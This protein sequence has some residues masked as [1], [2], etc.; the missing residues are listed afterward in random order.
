MTDKRQSLPKRLLN[1]RHGLA[2]RF[3]ALLLVMALIVAATGMFGIAKITFVGS[4]VQQMIRTRAAQEKIAILMKVAVQESRVHLL[5]ALAASSPATD[6]KFAMDDYEMQ[7]DRL[8]NYVNLLLTGNDKVG[9]EP[10]PPGSTLERKIKAVRSAWADF[11]SAATALMA[12]KGEHLAGAKQDPGPRLTALLN[13]PIAAATGKVERA[14]DDL[15]VTMGSLMTETREQVTEVQRQARIALL[16]VIIS[17]IVLALLLGWVATDRLVIRPLLVLKG[18]AEKI[19]TGD[20]SHPLPIRGRGEISQLGG[21]I[22]A[23]AANLSSLYTELEQRVH[24]RTA[25]LETANQL[26]EQARN[27]A[28]SA[29]IAK[30]SF[31]AHMSHEIRT[32]M[33][34]IIGMTRLALQT[35]LTARQR[36]YLNKGL[37]A[38]DSLL[39]IINDILDFSKIEAG[40]L[41]LESEEFLLENLFD[42]LAAVMSEQSQNKRLEFLLQTSADVPPSLVGDALRLGQV[43]INLCSNA[44]KFTQAG[45]VVLSTRLVSRDGEQLVLRFSVRDTGIGMSPEEIGRLFVP[46]TQADASITRKYGGTGLGLAICKKLVEMMGGAIEIKSAPGWGSEFSFTARFGAGHLEPQRSSTR[47]CELL[48][49]R[50]LIIDD[51]KSSRDI[52][53]EQ[54][55]SLDFRVAATASAREGIV[56]LE[57]AA[58]EPYELVIMDWIMPELDGIAAAALI[59]DQKTLGHKPKIILTTAYDC[60]EARQRATAAGLDGYFSKP[61]NL[62][63]LFDTIMTIFGREATLGPDAAGTRISAPRNGQVLHGARILLAEDNE[64]NQQV[65]VEY[66]SSAGFVTTVAANGRQALDRLRSEP[67]AAV[68]MDIQMPVMDGYETT[69]EIRAIPELAALPVIAMTAHA[70]TGTREKCLKAGMNDYLTKPIHLDELLSVLARWVRPPA[71]DIV[72]RPEPCPPPPVAD[73]QVFLPDLLPGISIPTGLRMC[74]GKR[75][76]FREMLLLFRETSSGAAAE[77]RTH[78]A[79]GDHEA[80]AK[81]AHSLKTT[82]GIIGAGA[83]VDI[84]RAIGEALCSAPDGNQLDLVGVFEQELGRIISSIDNGLTTAASSAPRPDTSPVEP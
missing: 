2:A 4:S 9:I 79:S 66:L 72:S 56:E 69:R 20:L 28:E 70:M 61:V 25:D 15:L 1:L 6:F 58:G 41:E 49:K 27:A 75:Q 5:E 35:D 76:L 10:A 19:S 16:S 14:I 29:N 50:V 60:E 55:A 24:E 36:E 17:A 45:E 13:E 3:T 53:T 51:N 57:A 7:R 31:L 77:L 33:N 30:G 40:R 63:V 37:F 67:F 44:V 48:G 39:R 22:N 43:L 84:T 64:F 21:A 54:L 80:A 38:A 42:K 59:R 65:A 81:T 83:L 23:M 73:S 62:S 47:G 74:N 32:P 18:A 82:A 68:L 11:E 46:F 78:L 26:L 52:F 12:R 71:Q 8:L 34:A